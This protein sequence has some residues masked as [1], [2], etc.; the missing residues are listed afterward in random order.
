VKVAWLALALVVC[1]CDKDD[2][3]GGS[4]DHKTVE[5]GDQAV[6]LPE[7]TRAVLDSW[8]KNELASDKM[9][10]AKAFGDKCS[11]GTVAKLDVAICEFASPEEA[12]RAEQAGYGWVGAT[13]GTAWVSGSLV[14]AVADR[15]KADPSGK[16]IN[17]LMKLT[18]K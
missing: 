8:K 10:V 7:A 14:I 5:S 6:A 18:P 16:T 15:A 3:T 13:T 17:Q 1:G 4:T 2:A 9:A 12:K 11:T